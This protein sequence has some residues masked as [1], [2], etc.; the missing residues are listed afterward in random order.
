MQ[1]KVLHEQVI[2]HGLESGRIVTGTGNGSGSGI[3]GATVVENGSVLVLIAF[4]AFQLL[5][6]SQYYE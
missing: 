6:C 5:G 2:G 3:V 1:K 4:V